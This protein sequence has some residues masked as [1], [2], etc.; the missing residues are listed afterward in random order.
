MSQDPNGEPLLV[1]CTIKD[2]EGIPISGVK[3]DIWETDSTGHYDVQYADRSGPDGRCVMH[4]DEKGDFWFKAIKPVPYPI[5]HDGPVGKL[6]KKLH[7]YPYRP[8]HVHFM[9]EKEGYD[10][11]ITYEFSLLSLCVPSNIYLL[12]F[13][14]LF[15]SVM[16]PMRHRTRFSVSRIVL[17][18]T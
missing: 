3:V 5:L 4:S 1:V 7:R 6:L 18:L 11:L 2:R 9:F 15:T 10:H 8:S 17:S 16:I 13:Q 14:D 12:H